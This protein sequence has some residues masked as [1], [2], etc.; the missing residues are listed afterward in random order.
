MRKSVILVVALMA[1]RQESNVAT[2]TAPAAAEKPKAVAVR[3][4]ALPF[5][6]A[7]PFVANDGVV[8]FMDEES[9]S[10]RM[11][12]YR[13]GKWSEPRTIATDP[14]MLINRADFP[15]I[16]AD[17]NNLV[18]AWSTRK[19]HGSIVHVAKS[20]DGGATWSAPVT[21]HPDQISQ[22]GFVSL[23]GD[24]FIFLDGR[25]LEGGMEGNGEMELR[26]GDGT[27]LDPRV[28]DC[29]QTAL[30][31]TS[32]GPIAAY[33]DRS[34]DEV[35]DISI[36]RKTAGGWTEP[37]T[38]HADGWKIPGC[39]VNG[40]QLDA[41]GKRVVAAW[42]TSANNDP[43]V[44]V[45]F[46]EDAGATFGKPIRVDAGSSKGRVDAVLLPDGAAAITWVT[47]SGDKS[48]LHARRV[49]P[50]GTLAAPV[51]LGE[52]A[53]FPRA[54][55]WGENVAVVWTRADGAQ[56]ALLERL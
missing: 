43:R 4:I 16:S 3:T 45:A 14:A 46:S 48:L 50:D 35:R 24:E 18:A 29:C 27:A 33:R 20:A 1:C 47:A 44:Y 37:K 13:D 55:R 10:F 11:A 5:K 28:C 49:H 53:G 31:M 6:A 30:A 42:F 39:P 51:S 26:S 8:S 34:P 38:L 15:S 7:V 23:A 12:T 21:P 19:E 17:G 36:V 22:F 9:K 2:A 40:P 54:A 41:E 32:D 52:A 56:L 25:K